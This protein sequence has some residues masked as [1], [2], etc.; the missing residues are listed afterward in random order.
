LRD[1]AEE[2]VARLWPKAKAVSGE[3]LVLRSLVVQVEWMVC[4][5]VVAAEG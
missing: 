4:K 1:E 5:T 3:Q 2:Q